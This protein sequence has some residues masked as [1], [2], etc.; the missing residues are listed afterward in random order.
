VEFQKEMPLGLAMRLSRDSLAMENFRLLNE[1]EQEILIL[2]AQNA[3]SAKQM[4]AITE[5]LHRPIR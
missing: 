1:Q 3:S 2:K 4:R 5:S